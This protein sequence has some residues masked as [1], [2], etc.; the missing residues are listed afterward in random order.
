MFKRLATAAGIL[1]AFQV[2][3]AA[4]GPCDSEVQAALAKAAAAGQQA[5]VEAAPAP[6]KVNVLVKQAKLE[7]AVKPAKLEV[8]KPA[9]LEANVKQAK[10]D[11]AAEP[12]K[13]EA[14]AKHRRGGGNRRGLTRA[15]LALL[16]RIESKFGPVNVISGYR[17]GARIAT[18]GRISRHASGNAA[19][20]DAGSRKGAIVKWLIANHHN[21]GTMTYSDMGHIHVDI[22]PHF[23]SLG[24]YSGR[25]GRRHARS[26]YR[27]RSERYAS[28]GYSRGYSNRRRSR[29][30]GSYAR[31]YAARHFSSG[32]AA[33][34]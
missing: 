31:S 24:A 27:G 33:V 7:T 29:P 15:M 18:T 22:G 28:S 32:Y 4:A 14:P 6:A 21:G 2:G 16:D 20:I 30:R 23:V 26:R 5:K 10:A 1:L 19:D 3:S 17:P 12:A 9:K 11:V 34:Y 13:T 8:L 25:T